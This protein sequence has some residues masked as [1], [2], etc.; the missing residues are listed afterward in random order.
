MY[1]SAIGVS[2]KLELPVSASPFSV[3]ITTGLSYF[4]NRYYYSGPLRNGTFITPIEAGGKYYFTKIGYFEGDFGV[5]ADNYVLTLL[6]N[7]S[8]VRTKFENTAFIYSPIIG[9]TAPTSKHEATVHI[10]LRYEARVESGG[11]VSQVAIRIA[12]RFKLTISGKLYGTIRQL[13][14]NACFSFR[15]L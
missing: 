3:V 10:G 9:F 2:A 8:P 11:T 12:Y 1:G 14:L 15:R 7:G 4:L 13:L 6:D 5:S